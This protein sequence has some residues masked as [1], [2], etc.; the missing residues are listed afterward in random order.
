[1]ADL[2]PEW[3][4]AMASMEAKAD[5]GFLPTLEDR[6]R[7][8]RAMLRKQGVRFDMPRLEVFPVK[9]GG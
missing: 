7:H 8:V 6:A 4:V 5:K 1:M 2:F 9:H 3:T